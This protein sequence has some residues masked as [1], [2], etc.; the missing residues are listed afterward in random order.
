MVTSLLPR[1]DEAATST[2]H[3]IPPQTIGNLRRLSSRKYSHSPLQMK[4]KSRIRSKVHTEKASEVLASRKRDW[5]LAI[6]F[7]F[8]NYIVRTFVKMWSLSLIVAALSLLASTSAASLRVQIPPSAILANP[9]SLPASTHATLTSA[10][11]VVLR[12]VLRKGNYIEFDDI[13]TIGSHLLDVFSHSYTFAPFRIDISDSHQITLAAE[14]YR[15]VQWSDHGLNYA[16][17]P[18]ENVTMNAKCTSQKNFY[19]TRQGFSPLSLLKNPMILMGVVALAFTFGMPKLMENM[20][21]E[22]KA[23][24]D[25]MQK[26]SPMGAMGRAMQGQSTGSEG[27]DLAG[28][29]AGKSASTGASSG[30]EGI[31]ERKR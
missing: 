24:Y 26:K 2:H 22:M 4:S 30:G 16:Q 19:E 9:N 21:P 5:H 20:D 18:S 27:F 29:L 6:I 17:A 15:G 8:S 3:S 23:E 10:Q 12:A 31:R 7:Q 13:S 1:S 14:T 25:E 11:G 28:F